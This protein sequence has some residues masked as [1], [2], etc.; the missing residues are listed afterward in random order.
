MSPRTNIAIYG[1][2]GHTGQLVARE[3]A[4][5]GREVVLAGRD[6]GKLK[7]LAGE[8]GGA[9]VR[10][11]ALDDERGLRELAGEAGVLVH[12]AGPFTHTGRQVA[13][14]AADGGCHYVDHALEQHHTA[15]MFD[16]MGPRARAAGITMVTA[17]SFYGGLG[18]LLAGAVAA[19]M[20]GIERVTVAYAVSDWM[21]TAGAKST[22]E[23]LFAD[24]RRI[25]YTGGAFHVGD[26]EPRNAVYPFPPP[27]GPRT[28]I[29][30]IPSSDVVTI[31]RH[32]RTGRV[33]AQLT[34]DTFTDERV[35][36]SEHVDADTRAGS[37]FTVAVQVVTADGNRAGQA[38]G[39]DLWRESALA[40]VEAAVRLADAEAGDGPGP[41]VYGPAEAFA[42]EPYLRDLE[43][44]GLFTLTLPAS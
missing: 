44:L 6:G 29:A 25:T 27:L 16:E 28:M 8:L 18:D 5:R 41:G 13:R 7:A 10:Q 34:A 36:T 14:A 3:L 2:S 39:H 22:A 24:T 32:V 40:S 33:E 42:A 30:P 1:A 9:Q 37:R 31:P 23:L 15:W 12:C 11:V 43:R 20:S 35:F 38:A 4:A 21:L 17:M 26:L 19:G